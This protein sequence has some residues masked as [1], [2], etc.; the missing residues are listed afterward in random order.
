MTEV[1][2]LNLCAKVPKVVPLASHKSIA[3]QSNSIC[4]SQPEILIG[5]QLQSIIIASLQE[6]LLCTE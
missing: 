1:S 5:D 6:Y 4:I 2:V 3:I